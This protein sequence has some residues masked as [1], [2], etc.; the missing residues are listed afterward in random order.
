M[1]TFGK[2][3][4]TVTL[5]LPEQNKAELNLLSQTPCFVCLWGLLTQDMLLS[6]GPVLSQLGG[7]QSIC[8][9]WWNNPQRGAQPVCA[10]NSH[11]VKESVCFLLSLFPSSWNKMWNLLIKANW[12]ILV[13]SKDAEQRTEFLLPANTEGVPLLED[14][15]CQSHMVL[16]KGCAEQGLHG[17][18]DL[19]LCCPVTSLQSHLHQCSFSPAFTL[20]LKKSKSLTCTCANDSASSMFWDIHC[21]ERS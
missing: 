6:Q 18:G 19:S 7:K 2:L 1:T 16:E 13:F 17:P 20:L 9:S 14:Y 4:L 10:D 5:L 3:R 12:E 21:S 11:P 15:A 8:K